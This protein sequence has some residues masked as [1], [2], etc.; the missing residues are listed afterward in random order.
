VQLLTV[1]DAIKRHALLWRWLNSANAEVAGHVDVRS[2]TRQ[3][4]IKGQFCQV[5]LLRLLHHLLE[6]ASVG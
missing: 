3:M 2:H 1:Y 5:V 6:A 4:P